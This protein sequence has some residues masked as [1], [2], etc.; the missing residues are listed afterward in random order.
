M[1]KDVIISVFASSSLIPAKSIANKVFSPD[2]QP[3]ILTLSDSSKFRNQAV[4][5][6]NSGDLFLA[7]LKELSPQ[8]S[9]IQIGRRILITFSIGWTF[10]DELLK[11]ENERNKLDAL[12]LIDGMHDKNCS[13][14]IEYAKQSGQM[15]SLMVM[16]HSQIIPP[17]ISSKETNSNIF[18]KAFELIEQDPKLSFVSSEIPEFI[19]DPEFPKQGITITSGEE[20]HYYNKDPFVIGENIGNLYRLEYKGNNRCIHI[21]MCQYVQPNLWKFLNN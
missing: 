3:I 1:I 20:F 12:L 21:F 19:I 14:W 7:A 18:K 10:A 4:K 13:H 17:F 8:N 6:L 11:S 5:W 16:A 2:N 9:N 15:D